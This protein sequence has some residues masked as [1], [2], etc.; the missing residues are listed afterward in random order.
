MLTHEEDV[1]SVVAQVSRDVIMKNYGSEEARLEVIEN[2]IHQSRPSNTESRER[3]QRVERAESEAF[4]R[5]GKIGPSLRRAEKRDMSEAGFPVSLAT[6]GAIFVPQ[7]S[8]FQTLVHSAMTWTS[9]IFDLASILDTPQHGR[10]VQYPA[11]TDSSVVGEQIGENQQTDDADVGTPS[12]TTLNTFKF[13]AKGI[14][15][16]RELSEDS[17]IDFSSYLAS[18]F[19]KRLGRVLNPLILNG[20]GASANTINGL[21]NGSQI[22]TIT[23]VGSSEN[24]GTSG[25]NTVGSTDLARLENA[26]DPSY[27]RGDSVRLM[28]SSATLEAL[29]RTLDKN[30][31][32]LY[33]TLNDDPPRLLGYK[34]SLNAAMDVPQSIQSSPP[35][36]RR[37]IVFADFSR[38]V[39]RR[40]P[41]VLIRS[42]ER[43]GEFD[44]LFFNYWARYDSAWVD[45]GANAA[46][47]QTTY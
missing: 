46:I 21:L 32:Q 20:G 6:G 8:L 35:V 2:L 25:A 17:P 5:S 47:L 7:G 27:R 15:I 34:V 28:M 22:T 41:A 29:R 38:L 45:T 33:P 12:L 16:S 39:I 18:I 19:G 42:A 4:V 40:G 43:F 26:V 3:K 44:Q 31:R 30:G 24:D 1:R 10:P 36:S 37:L 14:R 23:A 11:D 9:E 13:S